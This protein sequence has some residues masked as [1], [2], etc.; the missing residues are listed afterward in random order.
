MGAKAQTLTRAIRQLLEYKGWFVWKG[1]TGAVRLNEGR[2]ARFG[3]LGAADLFALKGGRLIALEIKS[4]TDRPRPAQISFGES[5]NSHGG[6]YLIVR[7]VTELAN[8][9]EGL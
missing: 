5:I 8:A 6:F 7:S 1:G 3:S 2:F 9:V 4:K